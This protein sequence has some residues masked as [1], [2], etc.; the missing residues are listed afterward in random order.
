[1]VVVEIVVALLI[2]VIVLPVILF[3]AA[4]RWAVVSPRFGRWMDERASRLSPR[5]GR[6]FRDPSRDRKD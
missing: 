6:W 4:Q 1:M 3:A 5:L 2:A